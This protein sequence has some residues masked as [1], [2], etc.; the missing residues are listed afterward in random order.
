M[1]VVESLSK[2]PDALPYPVLAIG[3]F[4]GVHRGHQT[5]LRNLVECAGA[6]KG[7]ALLLTFSP[8]PQK[9]I[10]PGDAPLLLQTRQQKHESL[11]KL[12][13]DIIVELPFTRRLSMLSPQQ[14]VEQVLFLQEVREVYVGSNFRFG[15]RRSGD[16]SLLEKLGEQR[17]CRVSAV[18]QVRLRGTRISST[19]V[20]HALL[21]GRVSLSRR[22]LG[23]PYEVVGT[24]VRGAGRGLK[25]GFP[26][27]N[28]QLENELVPANGVYSTRL[29]VN[30]EVFRS[31][32]NI[33]QRPTLYSNEQGEPTVETHLLGFSGDL[34][35]QSVRLE[36]CFRV[37]PDRKF[38]NVD[39]LKRQI[40]K[41]IARVDHWGKSLSTEDD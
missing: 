22:F 10:S 9:V 34:Y 16:F 20:R 36:F 37:R 24:V 40:E 23:R 14:F 29:S 2:L 4:D 1:I 17:L 39:R 12:G 7:S 3:V 35:G 11:S 30:G 8:H 31:I 18:P 33:G 5:I 15:H 21:S 41:D 25:L 26:T 28:L 27:A 32:T 19:K 6:M 38:D 13:I